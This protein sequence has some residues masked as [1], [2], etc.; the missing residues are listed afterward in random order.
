[1]LHIKKEGN[2]FGAKL[3]LAVVAVMAIGLVAAMTP[4]NAAQKAPKQNR[5]LYATG[6]TTSIQQEDRR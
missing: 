4:S 6:S 1:M 5:I 2:V 3:R